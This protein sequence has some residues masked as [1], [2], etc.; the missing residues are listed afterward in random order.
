MKMTFATVDH[1]LNHRVVTTYKRAL[2]TRRRKNPRKSSLKHKLSKIYV[3]ATAT[4]F[5]LAACGR[6]NSS[7]VTAVANNDE[8]ATRINDDKPT[9]EEADRPN[10][11]ISYTF[12]GES[13][14][15]ELVAQVK[16]GPRLPGSPA[17]RAAGDHIANTLTDYG[18]R[19]EE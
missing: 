10:P 6:T 4:A 7:D 2:T 11:I 13:S 8:V 14:Y 5:L 12:D 15:R 18:W 19:V 9:A 3:I 16:L 1:W 17:H